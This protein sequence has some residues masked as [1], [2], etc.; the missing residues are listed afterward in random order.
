MIRE[1][2]KTYVNDHQI[3]NKCN[4]NYNILIQ[5]EIDYDNYF[6]VQLLKFLEIEYCEVKKAVNHSIT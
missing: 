5:C 1:Q 6:N 2:L 4:N 3:L